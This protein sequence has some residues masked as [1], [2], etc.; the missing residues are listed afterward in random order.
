MLQTVNHIVSIS[1]LV[2]TAGEKE[3]TSTV[4]TGLNVYI[5]PIQESVWIAL[6]GEGAFNTFRLFSDNVNI[7]IWDKV[8]DEDSIVYIVKWTKSFD[9]IVWKHIECLINSEYD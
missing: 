6:D 9:S 1:R 7:L 2:E 8:T 4:H 5:E 3:Y